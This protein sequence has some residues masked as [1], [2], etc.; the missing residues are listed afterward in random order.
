M[1]KSQMQLRRVGR[2]E[3]EGRRRAQNGLLVHIRRVVSILRLPVQWFMRYGVRI[4]V[5]FCVRTIYC[6]TIYSFN[7]AVLPAFK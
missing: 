6:A 2:R 7:A 4:C 5:L 3:G 1:C